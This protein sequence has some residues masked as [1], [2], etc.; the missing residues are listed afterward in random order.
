MKNFLIVVENVMAEQEVIASM[1]A[2]SMLAALLEFKDHNPG[3]TGEFHAVEFQVLDSKQYRAEN[4]YI[5][6]VK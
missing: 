5:T 6:E 3:F 2:E 1:E 4:G